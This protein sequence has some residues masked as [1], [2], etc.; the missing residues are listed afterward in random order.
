MQIFPDHHGT[1]ISNAFKIRYWC[2]PFLTKLGNIYL[3]GC[4]YPWFKFSSAKTTWPITT[5]KML[6]KAFRFMFQSQ[7]F[8]LVP[9]TNRQKFALLSRWNWPTNLFF[10]FFFLKV[11]KKKKRKTGIMKEAGGNFWQFITTGNE[12]IIHWQLIIFI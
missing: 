7:N 1:R 9:V 8:K 6:P 12:N 2:F 5:R 3:F 11:E 4:M 10:I